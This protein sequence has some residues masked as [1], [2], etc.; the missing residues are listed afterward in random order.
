M[1]MT[2]KRKKKQV[3]LF[4]NALGFKFSPFKLIWYGFLGTFGYNYYLNLYT[5]LPEE[6]LGK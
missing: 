4:S 3:R 1:K 5:D 6:N 2:G